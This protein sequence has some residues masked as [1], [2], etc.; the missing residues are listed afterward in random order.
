M[1]Q[2]PRDKP[3]LREIP[4]AGTGLTLPHHTGV[5]ANGYPNDANGDAEK[6]RRSRAATTVDQRRT[7]GV[8]APTA[9]IVPMMMA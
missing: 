3:H 7:T 6:D 5:T 9:V 8:T 1:H 4:N 2:Q